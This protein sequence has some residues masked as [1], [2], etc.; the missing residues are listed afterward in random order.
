MQSQHLRGRGRRLAQASLVY[1]VRPYLTK[2]KLKQSQHSCY[3]V[4]CLSA[5]PEFLASDVCA[6]DSPASLTP[7]CV[8]SYLGQMRELPWEHFSSPMG[9]IPLL[10]R[11]TVRSLA[12]LIKGSRCV[13]I[14]TCPSLSEKILLSVSLSLSLSLSVSVSQKQTNKI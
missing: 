9:F 12:S 7:H 1:I 4:F 6:F 14:V 11:K 13:G 3:R 5:G 2:L 10:L 8:L